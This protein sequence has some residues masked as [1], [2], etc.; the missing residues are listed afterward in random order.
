MKK[1]EIAFLIKSV[2]KVGI[3]GGVFGKGAKF[4]QNAGANGSP[5]WI[6]E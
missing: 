2:E 6:V 1:T 4:Q 3:G 5:H